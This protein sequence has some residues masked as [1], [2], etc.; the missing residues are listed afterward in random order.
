MEKRGIPKVI[1]GERIILRKHKDSV[2]QEMFDLIQKN[3][4]RLAEF[5]PWVP[6]NKSVTDT[7]VYLDLCHENWL[8]GSEFNFG[9]FEREN[10][11][12]M[13]NISIHQIKWGN[14]CCELGYW[15]GKDYEGKGYVSEAIK[16]L[17]KEILKIGFHRIEIRCSP[18]NIRSE[19]IAKRL[20]Y[21]LEGH[22]RDNIKLS[23]RS[24]VY[25]DT[26]IFG[27]IREDF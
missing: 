1:E 15:L 19:A 25:R 9:I 2:R 4:Q 6:F 18:E 27:K 24:Q 13:G 12:Y 5:L 10:D 11:L 3:R 7:Q 26:L 8:Q 20:G 22:L 21:T 17:E 23:G 16:I 14:H